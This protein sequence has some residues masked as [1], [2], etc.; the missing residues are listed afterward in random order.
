MKTSWFTFGWGQAHHVRG[1]TFDP[2]VG[3]RITAEE[4]REVMTELFGAKWSME[5][6]ERPADQWVP[7][8]ILVFDPTTGGFAWESD[9]DR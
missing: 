6:D 5:Y 3:V 7:R 2:N 9:V 8:G 4:P 1:H